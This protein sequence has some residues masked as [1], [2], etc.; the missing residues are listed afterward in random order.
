MR[1]H[2]PLASRSGDRLYG[3]A[4]KILYVDLTDRRLT[5]LDT[6]DYLSWGGGHGMGSAVF[7]DRVPDKRIDGF[8]PDNVVTIM[9]S[10]LCGSLTPSAS[11]RTEVQ[12]I[13][14]QTYPV[15]WFTRSNFG[16]RFST[17]LKCAG[18][19]GLALGGA[20]DRPVWLDIRDGDVRIRDCDGLGLWGTDTWEC[21]RLICKEV[22]GEGGPGGWVRPGAGEGCTT[23]RPAVLAIGPAGENLCRV[24]CLIHETSCAAGQGGFGAVWGAKN[25]KAVSVIG[26]GGIEIA[27]PAG[28]MRA[29]L[30]Q[31]REYGFDRENPRVELLSAVGRF[32]FAPKPGEFYGPLLGMP[33]PRPEGK[34]PK[35]CVGCQSGCRARYESGIGNEGTCTATRVYPGAE[36]FEVAYTACDLTNRYGV[37]AYELHRGIPYLQELHRERVLGPRGEIPCDLDF[38]AYGKIEFFQALLEKIAYRKDPFGDALAEGFTRAAERWGRLEQDLRTGRLPFPYWGMPEH[39]YDPRTQV[40]WGYGSILGDR[41]INEHEFASI[42]LDSLQGLF[43]G[44]EPAAPAED[45][46]RI[47]TDRMEPYHRDPDRMSMMDYGTENIYSEHMA[48]LVAWHRH[49][50]RF[51]KQSMLFCDW[52]W[53]DFVN[54]MQPDREGSSGVAEPAFFRAVTGRE[55]SFGEGVELGRRIW[56][57]DHAIWTLQ[58]RHRDMVRYAEY[59]YTE[60]YP[61]LE[62]IPFM[63]YTLPGRTGGTWAYIDTSHRAIDRDGFEAFKTRFYRLEGWDPATGYPTRRTLEALGLGHVADELEAAGKL[64]IG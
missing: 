46:V 51:W 43:P 42:H 19:D 5:V 32:Y 8:H 48:K 52:R 55:L 6:R 54:I 56:N 53:P 39:Q 58:G 30:R 61:G 29:R 37:N 21:Q 14:V 60:P 22:A 57:L 16:G 17:L 63:P 2:G 11:G 15:G 10:P 35:G 1:Q 47:F 26:T 59:M 12:G 4:G 50:T 36:N 7:F 49:Y 27:D 44:Q 64:G 9:S 23:Q 62:G 28:L 18:W 31:S 33:A 41:D 20:A 3:Y 34:R 40:E 38:S 24:A 25:L 45:L 13:G